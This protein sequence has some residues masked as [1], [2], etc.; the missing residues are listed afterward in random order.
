MLQQCDELDEIEEKYQQQIF[1]L[2]DERDALKAQ[3][4]PAS[5]SK[6]VVQNLRAALTEGVKPL[7]PDHSMNHN[8]DAMME[9]REK[10]L[11]LENENNILKMEKER[12]EKVRSKLH[13][14]IP[15]NWRIIASIF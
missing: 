2:T 5:T 7:T 14:P 12:L 4:D 3:I 8:E 11:K 6:P 13:L 9:A 1:E 10:I 15:T